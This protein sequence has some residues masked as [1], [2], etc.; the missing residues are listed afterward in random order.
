MDTSD[1]TLTLDA[2]LTWKTEAL[3]EYF[4]KRGLAK[5]KAKH[6][7]CGFVLFSLCNVD[8]RNTIG[9]GKS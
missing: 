8:S 7:T 5:G 6:K 4:G 2:F 9:S 3:Y 1:Q